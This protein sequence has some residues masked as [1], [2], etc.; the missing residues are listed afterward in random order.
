[1]QLWE[2]MAPGPFMHYSSLKAWQVAHRLALEVANATRSFPRHERFELASQL[3][4]AS[5]SAPTNLVEG[6]AR[7]GSREALRFTLIAAASLLE[8]DYLLLFALESGYLSENEH[9]R[10]AELRSQASRLVYR[11]ARS[12]QSGVD[13][14]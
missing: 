1:V 11:L 8:T 3:R 2:F 10:L 4:R 6:Q 13:R 7:Y 9:A 5:L 12:L 14:R